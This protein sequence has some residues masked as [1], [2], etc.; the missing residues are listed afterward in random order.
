LWGPRSPLSRPGTLRPQLV[1]VLGFAALILVGTPPL[2]LPASVRG[3]RSDPMTALLTATSSTPTPI[4]R[5]WDR[6]CS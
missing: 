4:G 1:V 3:G 6:S 2:L 5:R